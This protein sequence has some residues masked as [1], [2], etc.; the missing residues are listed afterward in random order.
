MILHLATFVGNDDVTAL[1]SYRCGE[2]L[3][4]RPGADFRVAATL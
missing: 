2:S 3:R 1:R 4:L